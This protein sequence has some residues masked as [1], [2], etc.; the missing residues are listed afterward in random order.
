MYLT[1]KL[2]KMINITV[3]LLFADICF[4]SIYL[5]FVFYCIEHVRYTETIKTVLKDYQ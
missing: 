4:K 3:L 1:Q 5:Y 2:Y